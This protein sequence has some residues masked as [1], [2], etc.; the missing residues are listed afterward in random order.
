[1][2]TVFS[3]M[4]QTTESVKVGECPSVLSSTSDGDKDISLCTTHCRCMRAYLQNTL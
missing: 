1:M 4:Q 3:H 2:E